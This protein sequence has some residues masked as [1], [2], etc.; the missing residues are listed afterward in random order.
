MIVSLFQRILLVSILGEP[1]LLH[2]SSAYVPWTWVRSR[3]ALLSWVSVP[4]LRR[5]PCRKVQPLPLPGR[6]W[7]FHVPLLAGG[8]PRNGGFLFLTGAFPDFPSRHGQTG[9]ALLVLV[10]WVGSSPHR[11]VSSMQTRGCTRVE[12]QGHCEVCLWVPPCP[13]SDIG[14]W[15]LGISF[16]FFHIYVLKSS[17]CL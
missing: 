9:P 5:C 2:A 3:P 8:S 10:W 14:F 13:S 17:M 7:R 12:R 11:P 4:W 1:T 15:H 16:P 6:P